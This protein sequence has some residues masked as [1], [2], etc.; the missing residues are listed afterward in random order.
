[1]HIGFEEYDEEDK[2]A[3]ND[4]DEPKDSARRFIG[5]A[6]PRKAKKGKGKK[7]LKARGARILEDMELQESQDLIVLKL[8][9]SVLNEIRIEARRERQRII[10]ERREQQ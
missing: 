9:I 2:A 10:D 8:H 4:P 5:D 3:E 6:P 7:K 1:V